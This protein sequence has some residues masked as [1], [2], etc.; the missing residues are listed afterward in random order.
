MD[1]LWIILRYLFPSDSVRRCIEGARHAV[2]EFATEVMREDRLDQLASDPEN[3]RHLEAAL[4]AYEHA[5]R[6]A[7]TM[8][9][10]EIASIDFM[11]AIQA[12]YTPHRAKPLIELLARLGDM[13]QTSLDVE[14]LAQ[15]HAVKLTRLHDAD[16][17]GL[18]AHSDATCAASISTSVRSGLILS[19]AR[20]ARPSK[21]EAA[22]PA[23]RHANSRD[24]PVFD[25]RLNQPNGLAGVTCEVATRSPRQFR[26]R[27]SRVHALA[28]QQT[29]RP[30]L[31]AFA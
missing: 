5:L 13:A 27:I 7:I 29:T 9:A 14:R 26:H 30:G 16:P 21:D 10:C 3:R 24:P 17:L 4:I 6:M 1:W 15:L 18:A 31:E 8:R 12:S 19:S 20:S 23:A 28:R 22:L 25:V 11:P 2:K